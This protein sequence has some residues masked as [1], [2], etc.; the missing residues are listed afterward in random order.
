MHDAAPASAGVAGFWCDHAMNRL[1]LLRTVCAS[2]IL[3][4][5]A[6]SGTGQQP[7][8]ERAKAIAEYERQ[9]QELQKKLQ[10]LKEPGPIKLTAAV[11]SL[12]D[13]LPASWSKLFTW[14]GIGPANM[15]GR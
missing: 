8:A 15:G 9:I 7:D 5:I 12:D 11:K 3:F 14:R 1:S 10:A 13:P 6:L 2:I 4:G